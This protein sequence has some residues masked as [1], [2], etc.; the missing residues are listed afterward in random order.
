MLSWDNN[1]SLGVQL[2]NSLR[3]KIVADELTGS[4]KLSEN[5]IAKEYGS[6]RAP[7]REALRIL[8]NEGLVSLT[9]QGVVVK[10]LTEEDLRAFYDVRFMLETFAFTHIQPETIP[11]LADQLDVFTDRMELA[12]M[13]RDYK[14]FSIQDMYFHD[15][16]FQK[17]Q[18]RYVKLFW[19]NIK[20]LSQAINYVGTKKRIEQDECLDLESAR[21]HGNIAKALREGDHDRLRKALVQHFSHYNGWIVQDK[22]W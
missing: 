10:G 21:N 20:Y 13:H 17:I 9:K 5:L 16:V 3:M 8:E 6:S 4:Q 7:V 1:L 14:E 18:H 15:L 12:V 11:D 2:A 19:N 22:F